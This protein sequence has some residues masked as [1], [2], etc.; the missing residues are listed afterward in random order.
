MRHFVSSIQK[1]ILLCTGNPLDW[2]C[3]VR[4][5]FKYSVLNQGDG[6]GLLKDTRIEVNNTFTF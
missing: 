2:L 3:K 1:N 6:R 5:T 4:E